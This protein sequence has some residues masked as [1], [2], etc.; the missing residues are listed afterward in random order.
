MSQKQ[1][2]REKVVKK[3]LHFRLASALDKYGDPGSQSR[4]GAFADKVTFEVGQA[5]KQVEDQLAGIG[6][7]I[8]SVLSST[9]K[10]RRGSAVCPTICTRSG[11]D[12]P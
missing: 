4:V 3:P 11:S 1:H 8:R 5:S 10:P 12:L 9:R 2:S 6:A 7:G